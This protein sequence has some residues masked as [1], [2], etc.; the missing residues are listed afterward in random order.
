MKRKL[1]GFSDDIDKMIEL[2]NDLEKQFLYF[3]ELIPYHH[4]PN[5]VYSPR[6]YGIIQN[7]CAQIMAMMQIPAVELGVKPSNDDFPSY[8][9]VLNQN[10][11]LSKQKGRTKKKRSIYTISL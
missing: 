9:G 3:D 11:L 10:N 6:L 1:S 2:A 5:N 7:T 8:Y 4:N